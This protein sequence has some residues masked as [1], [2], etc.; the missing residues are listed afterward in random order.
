[1]IGI[2]LLGIGSG[3]VFVTV[4]DR[5][6]KLQPER[7]IPLCC[8][9]AALV[10]PVGYLLVA[11]LQLNTSDLTSPIEM[12]TLAVI[13]T[14][15]FLPFLFVGIVLATIFGARADDI[16]RLYFADLI[17]AGVGCALIVPLILALTPPGCVIRFRLWNPYDH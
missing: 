1:M 12:L 6:R 5:L 17:G 16:N 4:F 3:G 2:S 10:V 7:L 14:A 8:A 15:V 13:C 11:R 9:A